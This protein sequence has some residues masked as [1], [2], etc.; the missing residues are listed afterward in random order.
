MVG[1]DKGTFTLT[2][3]G[4]LVETEEVNKYLDIEACLRSTTIG[5]HYGTPVGD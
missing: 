3:Y 5:L 2:I 1:G 4:H